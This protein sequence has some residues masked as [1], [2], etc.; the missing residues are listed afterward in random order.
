MKR[1]GKGGERPEDLSLL[2]KTNL[3]FYRTNAEKDPQTGTGCG[4]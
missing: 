3:K 1:C 2:S 4:V